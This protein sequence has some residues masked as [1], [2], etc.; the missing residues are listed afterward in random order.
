MV[1]VIASF[2][3]KRACLASF[4]AVSN[5]RRSLLGMVAASAVVLA[6]LALAA[7]SGGMGETVGSS[8]I[9][10]PNAELDT[11]KPPPQTV[12]QTALQPPPTVPGASANGLPPTIWNTEHLYSEDERAKIEAELAA[13]GRHQ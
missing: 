12:T 8:L 4:G 5:A 2:F 3:A 13:A 7:C 1:H 9:T 6:T 10:V 11:A